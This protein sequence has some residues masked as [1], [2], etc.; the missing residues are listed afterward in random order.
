MA[1]RKKAVEA[2]EVS[3]R[4]RVI[5]EINAHFESNESITAVQLANIIDMSDKVLRGKLRSW[6]VRDQGV[7]KNHPWKLTLADAT[8]A[9]ERIV[10]N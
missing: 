5:N 1:Q 2:V 3:E 8:S 9:V 4:D 7:E 6:K 10:K